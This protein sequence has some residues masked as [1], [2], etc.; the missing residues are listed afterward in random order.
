MQHIESLVIFADALKAKGELRRAIDYYKQGLVQHKNIKMTLG[1][2]SSSGPSGSGT[3]SSGSG[4]ASGNKRSAASRSFNSASSGPVSSPTSVGIENDAE[5]A[6]ASNSNR[7]TSKD[8]SANGFDLGQVEALIKFRIA[9]CYSKLQQD[10]A[11]LKMLESITSRYRTSNMILA[12]AELYSRLGMDRPTISAYREALRSSPYALGAVDA[13]A[14]L[15]VPGA[16]VAQSVTARANPDDLGWLLNYVE[17]QSEFALSQHKAAYLSFHKLDKALPGQVDVLGCMAEL[18][19]EL[20]DHNSSLMLFK[21]ARAADPKSCARMDSYANLLRQQNDANRLNSLTREL[22]DIDPKRPEAWV[23]AAHFCDLNGDTNNTS[24]FVSKA[25]ELDPSHVSAHQLKG[26][27][28]LAV[29]QPELSVSAMYKAYSL[30]RDFASYKGLV[31]AYLAVPKLGEALRT[32]KEALQLMPKDSR[33]M[34]LL[35]R[36]FAQTPGD[37]R[38]KA[39]KAY[40]KALKLDPLCHEAAIAFA[41]LYLEQH[42]ARPSQFDVQPAISLLTASLHHQSKD[43]LH[44]KLGDLYTAAT[45][46]G[47]ALEQYHYALSIN[48]DFAMAKL[49]IER[50]E[51]LKMGVDP[52][53]DDDNEYLDNDDF[54]RNL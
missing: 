54:D 22:M 2:G 37:G 36:V 35:G 10:Q 51:K 41:D 1:L 18:Q 46:Y 17:A 19:L 7:G 14:R 9:R 40:A 5:K 43:F 20:G 28:Q 52:D 47:P 29:G 30:R 26:Q 15:G 39:S 38:K 44:V 3:S 21:K 45:E 4:N 25:L 53:A 48:Q 13:L 8:S 6:R 34:L 12:M 11:A 27:V 31:H 50:V 16:D 24:K 33:T 32:A 42:R 23:S 49:G